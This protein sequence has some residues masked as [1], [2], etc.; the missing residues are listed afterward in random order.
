MLVTKRTEASPS[1]R[2]TPPVWALV[3]GCDIDMFCMPPMK[4]RPAQVLVF[5]VDTWLYS[6]QHISP[7]AQLPPC[8]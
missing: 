3:G 5:G 6:V 8:Q 7:M 4:P 1:T 2:L